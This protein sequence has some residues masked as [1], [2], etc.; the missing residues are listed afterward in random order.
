MLVFTFFCSYFFITETPNKL[1]SHITR[2]FI[3]LKWLQNNSSRSCWKTSTK[4]KSKSL[5]LSRFILWSIYNLLFLCCLGFLCSWCMSYCH[6]FYFISSNK[7]LLHVY[8]YIFN[9][10]WVSEYLRTK[11]LYF[12]FL[13]EIIKIHNCDQ[14]SFYFLFILVNAA[15]QFFLHA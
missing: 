11:F 8:I 12:T 10:E 15:S 7:T 2:S 4:Y 5:S 6:I 9:V 3:W 13:N 1:P 14:F